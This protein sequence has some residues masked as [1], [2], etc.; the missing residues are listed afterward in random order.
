ML[1]EAGYYA[2]MALGV[3]KR[4]RTPPAADGEERIRRQLQ[5]REAIFLETVQRVI[6]ANPSHPYCQ[7]FRLAGCSCEDL[8]AAVKRD[9]LE[10]T[11]A[12][13]QR[14]GVYLSHDE[15]KGVQ[16]II[17]SGRHIPAGE[18]SFS[19]PLVSGLMESL[20]GG[21]RSKGTRTRESIEYQT[22]REG[23]ERLTACEFG[24]AGR[25]YILVKPILPSAAGFEPLLRTWRSGTGVERWFALGGTWA[26]AGHYR[27]ATHGLVLL[28]R[29][30]GA[31]A[32]LPT[33][34][35]PNDF[36]PVAQWIA[37]RRAEGTPGVVQSF[38]SAAVRVAAAAVEHGLDI[39][40]ALFLVSGEALTDAKREVIEAAGA[41]VYSRYIVTELGSVGFGCRHMRTGNCVHLF[42]DALAAINHRRCAPL[43][44][45]EV[46]SLLFTTL[47]PFA[48][49]VLINAEMDDSGVLEKASCDCVFARAGFTEQIRDVSSFGKLTGQGMTLVGSDLVRVLEEVLPARFGGGPG[50]YQLVEHEGAV[51]TQLTLRVSRRVPLSSS[52]EVEH[53]FLKEIRRF[54]GGTLAAR[55]WKHA[56]GVQV[57][58]AEPLLTAGG[59]ILPLHLLRTG[60]QACGRRRRQNRP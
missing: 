46:D 30:L 51:Q 15:F 19:N 60:Y 12:A 33:Y 52:E 42:R 24:L 11:L 7:M 8:A 35:A 57:I 53:F 31:K 39:S 55:V 54:Y 37:R 50:D 32:P 1:R 26:D 13:I 21:S 5:N 2:S 29:L 4:L 36:L 6:F 3:Y 38:P 56:G 10:A 34:L 28:S 22:Y 48:P 44:D 41:Q 45:A 9:G 43:A 14:Q 18:N 20:T 47:L 58:I 40:G 16:P 23:Y 17:R 59:K 49:C 25:A 27:A